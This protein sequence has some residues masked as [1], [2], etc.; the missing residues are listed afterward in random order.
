MLKYVMQA[1]IVLA[2]ATAYSQTHFPPPDWS[3]EPAATFQQW[4]FATGSNP[5]LAETWSNVGQAVA[6]VQPH[7]GASGWW[8]SGE[9]FG[10]RQ[11]FWELGPSGTIAI[12]LPHA[13]YEKAWVEVIFFDS[14]VSTRVSVSVSG[15]V[16]DGGAMNATVQNGP[17]GTWKAQRTQWNVQEDGTLGEIA[18]T[19]NSLDG[20]VVSDVSIYA[21]PSAYPGDANDDCLVD[22]RDLV[23]VRNR[24]GA[25]A[26]SGEGKMAD[27]NGD[28][29]VDNADLIFVRNRLGAACE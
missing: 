7:V 29:D 6:V 2:A 28:A 11:G 18:V 17:Y 19:G 3:E 15:A 16:Q 22:L 21:L 9:L 12:N 8:S 5:I 26:S 27:V 10:S 4:I 1:V 23:F 13:K 25:D 20:S 24:L 14:D